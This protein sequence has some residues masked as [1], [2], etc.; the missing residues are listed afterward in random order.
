VV[1]TRVNAKTLKDTHA[2]EA[3]ALQAAQAEWQRIQRGLATL[4]LKLAMGRPELVP[5]TPVTVAGFKPAINSTRWRVVRVASQLDES[6]YTQAVELEI[7][8]GT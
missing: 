2:T 3:D 5:Q 4:S 8:S 7:G 1:G 6:G